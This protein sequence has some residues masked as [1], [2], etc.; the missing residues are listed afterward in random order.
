MMLQFRVNPLR[1]QPTPLSASIPG[2]ATVGV[3]AS[4]FGKDYNIDEGSTLD[5]ED[6][7]KSELVAVA[8]KDLKGEVV[9]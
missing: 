4:E 3:T 6:Y 7:K 1:I 8:K 2:E 9:N 5:F